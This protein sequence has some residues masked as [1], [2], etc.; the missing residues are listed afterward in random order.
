M[1][2][3]QIALVRQVG[4]GLSRKV[5]DA[6]SVVALSL[7]IVVVLTPWQTYANNNKRDSTQS[8]LTGDIP[9]PVLKWRYSFGDIRVGSAVV[10]DIDQDGDIEVVGCSRNANKVSCLKGADG[11]EKWTYTVDH[12]HNILALADVDGDGK[13]EVLV[14]QD[15]Y[16]KCLEEDGTEKWSYYHGDI[17]G[18]VPIV[19][20]DIDGD[21]VIEVV[22]ITRVADC[23]VFCLDG[24]DGTEKWTF[25]ETGVGTGIALA[26]ADIDG[27]GATEIVAG[28]E[29]GIYC[30]KG[31]DGT[32]KWNYAREGDP[33]VIALADVDGDGKLEILMRRDDTAADPGRYVYCLEPDGTEKWVTTTEYGYPYDDNIAAY[34]IDGDGVVEMLFQDMGT[35][36][37]WCF[38]AKTGA[39]KWSYTA[40][41][42]AGCG[43]ALADIDGDGKMEVIIHEWLGNKNVI[44]LED[45]GTEK[46]TYGT[47]GIYFGPYMPSI[48]DVDG[49][50]KVE[51]LAGSDDYY[52]YC[53]KG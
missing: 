16:I 8:G 40:S 46:W 36:K 32:K 44:A 29:F 3:K 51:V 39:E 41:N 9:S 21:G 35:Y 17:D 10:G 24:R 48:D 42:Y 30:L 18:F 27:D 38:N 20:D 49:D 53:L 15:N 12:Y 33:K 7:P 5:I 4:G 13:L 14:A 22:C 26:S 28:L 11:S 43:V 6:S 19:A 23:T 31:S 37:T 47:G 34:D 52:L 45:D 50:G 25:T 2:R 1:W